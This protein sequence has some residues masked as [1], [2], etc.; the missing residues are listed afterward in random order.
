[1]EEDLLGVAGNTQ[2]LFHFSF[3]ILVR[4]VPYMFRLTVLEETNVVGVLTEAAT[5]NVQIIL[6]DEARVG[7]A[8]TAKELDMIN[9]VRLETEAKWSGREQRRAV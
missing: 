5:A 1:M 2:L 8:G 9:Y 6:T 7:T 4:Q 3:Y